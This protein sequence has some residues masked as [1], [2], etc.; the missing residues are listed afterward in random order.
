[1]KTLTITWTFSHPTKLPLHRSQHFRDHIQPFILY[2]A[3]AQTKRIFAFQIYWILIVT[4]DNFQLFNFNTVVE[5]RSKQICDLKTFFDF[6]ELSFMGLCLQQTDGMNLTNN[7]YVEWIWIK[8]TSDKKKTKMNSRISIRNSSLVFSYFVLNHF[9]IKK[10]LSF[11][12]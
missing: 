5:T 2:T 9:D 7:L 12:S 8:V 10:L 3:K 6:H 1:M 11:S 4:I